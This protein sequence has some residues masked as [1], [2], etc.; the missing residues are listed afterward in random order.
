VDGLVNTRLR[1]RWQ[2]L[3]AAAFALAVPPPAGAQ[4]GG[5]ADER[6]GTLGR[7][8]ED[9][10]LARARRAFSAFR[11][12]GNAR[13]VPHS[14]FGEFE[15]TYYQPG[16]RFKLTVPVSTN[17]ALRLLV[18]GH[19][20]IF[21]FHDVETDLFGPVSSSDPFDDLYNTTFRLQGGY[22]LPTEA[23]L[24]HDDERWSFVGE[25]FVKARWEAGASFGDGV[26]GGGALAVGYKIGDWLELAL[27]ASI[28]TR[29]LKS[30]VSVSPV[31]EA[32]WRFADHWTI[33]S[34]GRGAEI[35]YSFREGLAAFVTGRME[36]NSYRLADRGGAIG[37]GRLKQ[38]QIP[39]ALGVRWDFVDY[40]RLTATAGA[41]AYQR[42]KIQ[43]E[44]RDTVSKV[45]ADA[46][47]YFEIRFD[48]RP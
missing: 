18:R 34:R 21:D 37:Q 43:N 33:A 15:T 24:L 6:G 40:M 12:R 46:T 14:D 44:N 42:I 35:E 4:D 8:E 16:G 20:A 2:A 26:D 41:M 30:S 28:Q 38:R 29:M 1:T 9:A 48:L 45:T 11:L 31:F 3:L 27:G 22:Q 32:K 36:G 39:V 13:F 23:S 25:G 19:A 10:E 17:A 7:F 5:P 47:P